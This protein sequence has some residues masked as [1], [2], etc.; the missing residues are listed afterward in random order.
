MHLC[1][2]YYNRLKNPFWVCFLSTFDYTSY[3]EQL[4]Y[5]TLYDVRSFARVISLV[6]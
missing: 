6:M 3:L 2:R 4:L 1:L 5:A